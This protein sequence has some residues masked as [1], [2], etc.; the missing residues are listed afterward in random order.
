[1]RLLCCICFLFL[2]S[3]KEVLRRWQSWWCD[4]CAV[5]LFPVLWMCA[6]ARHEDYMVVW[7]LLCHATWI[8]EKG[9][10][11][12]IPVMSTGCKCMRMHILTKWMIKDEGKRR[13]RRRENVQVINISLATEEVAHGSCLYSLPPGWNYPGT[14]TAHCSTTILWWL[15][16]PTSHHVKKRLYS[17]LER[18]CLI[19]WFVGMS[20]AHQSKSSIPTKYLCAQG[21][22]ERGWSWGFV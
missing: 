5:F 1:M 13:G 8:S 21:R 11:E 9:Y 4:F 3:R 18:K 10:D 15:I 2:R 12:K 14:F 19:N 16:L 7:C 6:V 17:K 20:R 22:K